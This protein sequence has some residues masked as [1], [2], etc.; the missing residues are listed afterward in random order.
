MSKTNIKENID[1]FLCP[2][3]NKK[4][5]YFDPGRIVCSNKHNYDL[6]RSGYINLLLKTAKTD[7]DKKLFRSRNIIF[8]SKFY[9]PLIEQVSALILKQ[10]FSKNSNKLKILD[11][12]CGEGS[13]ITQIVDCLSASSAIEVTSFGIDI[14]KDAIKIA[15]K[16]YPGIVW[17]V[18]DLTR[19]PFTN[20]QFNVILSL[21]SPSNYVE[22]NR[23]ISED[24]ILLKVIPN[25]HYLYELRRY[26]YDKTDKE[27]YS[28]KKVIEHF[29]R[30]FL[31][32][33]IQQISY[34]IPINQEDLEH[35][36]K[37]TPLTWK[38]STEKMY[39]ILNSGINQV[40][41]D[42]MIIVGTKKK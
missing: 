26:F 41:V 7:Y 37:M 28:N 10:D 38:A 19:I 13:H 22:F 6:A 25:E 3:C 29:K 11:A 12:G 14:S 16:N 9:E 24:G 31:A 32:I 30:S 40:T 20:S 35:F 8:K 33:E 17:C 42:L 39:G 18:G 1:L 27:K 2:I 36:I 4:M 23:V 15:S 21:L 34:Q 5:K